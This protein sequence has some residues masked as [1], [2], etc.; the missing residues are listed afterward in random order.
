MSTRLRARHPQ[1][2]KPRH[3]LLGEAVAAPPPGLAAPVHPAKPAGAG[4]MPP[5]Y[6]AAALSAAA[7][8]AIDQAHEAAA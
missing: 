8:A 7:D 4:P 6:D 3:R 1:D 5:A 2:L